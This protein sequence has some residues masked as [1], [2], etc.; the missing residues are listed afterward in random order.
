M[1]RTKSS[2]IRFLIRDIYYVV[3]TIVRCSIKKNSSIHSFV[4]IERTIS[5]QLETLLT[6]IGSLGGIHTSGS[7]PAHN[8]PLRAF[9]FQH[10]GVGSH[11]IIG[12]TLVRELLM[13]LCNHHT[14]S[15]VGKKPNVIKT[16]Y[17]V[18]FH[19]NISTHH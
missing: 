1:E 2:Y 12:L 7:L 16:P 5:H 19:L 8:F 10:N 15:M 11:I 14:C 6:R 13:R 4:S 18:N 9:F 17:F 3:V